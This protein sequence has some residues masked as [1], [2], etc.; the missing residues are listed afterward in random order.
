MA[1]SET[2]ARKEHAGVAAAADHHAVLGHKGLGQHLLAGKAVGHVADL[3]ARG[4]AR[5]REP[6]VN[7][8]DLAIRFKHKTLGQRI[9]PVICH[10]IDLA[11]VLHSQVALAHENR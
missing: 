7:A 3:H 8:A 11:H 10:G 9:S 2:G 4:A 1:A 6:E 5:S